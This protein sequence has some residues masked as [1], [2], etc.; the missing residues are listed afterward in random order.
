MNYLAPNSKSLIYLVNQAG[1]ADI[2]SSCG[3]STVR[4]PAVAVWGSD[5]IVSGGQ[6]LKSGMRVAGLLGL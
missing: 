4:A 5:I 6:G 1:E 2:S 3:A